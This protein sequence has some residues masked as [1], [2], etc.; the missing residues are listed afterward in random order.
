MNESFGATSLAD[1]RLLGAAV[2]RQLLALGVRAVYVTFV[3]ELSRLDPAVVSMVSTVEPDDP[4]QRTFKVVRRPADGRA[5]AVCLAERH[6]LT[7]RQLKE[8]IAS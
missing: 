3:D 5:Y 1:S 6:G 4:N 2:L 7:A 8:R